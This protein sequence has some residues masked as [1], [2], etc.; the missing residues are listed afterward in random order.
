MSK[1]ITVGFDGSPEATEALRWATHEANARGCALE[2]MTCYH[3]PIASDIHA[4][5]V[6]LEAYGQA[7][8]AAHAQLEQAVE[9]SRSGHGEVE[10]KEV[11]GLLVSEELLCR[12]NGGRLDDL[13]LW[14]SRLYCELQRLPE[15]R[16]IVDDQEPDR[17][18]RMVPNDVS[19]P[20][21]LQNWA[22]GRLTVHQ[23]G[24]LGKA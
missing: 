14:I 18:W 23:L 9:A 22:V 21:L 24:S 5:W 6:P 15:E 7:E 16:M 4:G 20:A 17:H 19:S 2:I 3:L 10:Q 8:Q 11:E 1:H 12:G 13:G